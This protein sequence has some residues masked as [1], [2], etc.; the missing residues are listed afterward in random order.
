MRDSQHIIDLIQDFTA[1]NVFNPWRDADAMDA[2]NDAPMWRRA[3]LIK[4]FSRDPK[5][6]FVGEAPGY[7]GCK[8]TGVPFTSERLMLLDM[9]PDVS[10]AE[11]ITK[12]QTSV[13]E[14]SATIVWKALHVMNLA[15]QVV[16]WNAFPWHPHALA[17]RESNRT[18]TRDELVA[19]HQVLQSVVEFFPGAKVFAV[20][21]CAETSLA[22]IGITPFACLR[23]PAN[24]GA[25]KFKMALQT[26]VLQ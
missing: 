21:K 17:H 2:R 16:M 11:R 1:P 7:Q 18:P 4:H 25:A 5:Y 3:R 24:G 8:W 26:A 23:H 22:A 10:V 12:Y 15:E 9:I 20:G 6:L 19:G 13:A 14:P